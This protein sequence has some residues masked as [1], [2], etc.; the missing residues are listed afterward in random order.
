MLLKVEVVEDL[1]VG[2]NVNEIMGEIFIIIVFVSDSVIFV[3][4]V[5]IVFWLVVG[6]YF[7]M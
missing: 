1:F 4:G 3:E 2:V 5:L 7:K 6:D